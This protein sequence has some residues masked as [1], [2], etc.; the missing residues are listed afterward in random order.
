ML[1]QHEMEK[2][3][4]RNA[5]ATEQVLC[6]VLLWM[7]EQRMLLHILEMRP[8]PLQQ[9]LLQRLVDG[10]SP[11][12]IA[13]ELNKHPQTIFW[14]LHKTQERVGTDNLYQTIALAI[15]RRWIRT[16]RPKQDKKTGE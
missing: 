2:T 9:K 6:N 12:Q 8:T 13:L 1:Y 14:H 11:K 16:P 4:P 15:Q 5:Y 3:R 7:D 10:K